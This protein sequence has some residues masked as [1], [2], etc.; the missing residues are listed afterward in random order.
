MHSAAWT[1]GIL[2]ILGGFWLWSLTW[3]E[4]ENGPTKW[5]DDTLREVRLQPPPRRP[6]RPRNAGR[7]T[8]HYDAALAAAKGRRHI[9]H[10][11]RTPDRT[12]L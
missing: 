1:I 6:G 10:G 8:A 4:T 2:A 7:T 5:Y 9:A 12:L 11:R 3:L